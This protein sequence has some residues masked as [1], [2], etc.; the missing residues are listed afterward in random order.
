MSGIESNGTGS[1]NSP[2]DGISGN[3]AAPPELLRRSATSGC[4]S[5]ASSIEVEES[6]TSGG[7]IAWSAPPLHPDQTSN[8]APKSE[9]TQARS[10]LR[11]CMGSPPAVL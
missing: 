2:A 8:P 4:S 6:A 7:A 10:N 11:M 3:E 1:I 9:K 5:R